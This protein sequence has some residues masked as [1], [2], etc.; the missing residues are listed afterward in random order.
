MSS[1]DAIKALPIR[2]I[3]KKFCYVVKLVPLKWELENWP[4]VE[5]VMVIGKVHHLI[6]L[7]ISYHLGN[8][9]HSP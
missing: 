3:N 5:D 7:L 6:F 4:S 9:I 8:G 2:L 1:A